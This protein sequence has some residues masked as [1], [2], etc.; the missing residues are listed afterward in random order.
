[1]TSHC[2]FLRECQMAIAFC[3]DKFQELCCPSLFRS[4]EVYVPPDLMQIGIIITHKKSITTLVWHH[5]YGEVTTEA[6][7]AGTLPTSTVYC[8]ASPRLRHLS[9]SLP[10]HVSQFAFVFTASQVPVFHLA[11]KDTTSYFARRTSHIALHVL[12]SY[13]TA[14]SRATVR[15]AFQR[16]FHTF[17]FARSRGKRKVKHQTK[18]DTN[19]SFKSE[20]RT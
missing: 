12:R 9:S 16:R 3:G 10:I 8:P 4:I 6:N 19:T 13:L 11:F 20:T 18:H 15:V 7:S 5:G 1:M 14:Q 2:A 17:H